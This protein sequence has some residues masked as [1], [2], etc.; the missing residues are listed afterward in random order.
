[1][2]SVKTPTD[3]YDAPA[4]GTIVNENSSVASASEWTESESTRDRQT[5]VVSC[6]ADARTGQKATVD[7][8]TGSSTD[9]T[10]PS[11][12]PFEG[13]DLIKPLHE[14]AN[15]DGHSPFA[16][17]ASAHYSALTSLSG[18]SK[19]L[20]PS[21]VIGTET[22]RQIADPTSNR[23]S[24]ASIRNDARQSELMILNTENRRSS[25]AMESLTINKL[26][27]SSLG[28]VGRDREISVLESC[29]GRLL[30]SSQGTENRTAD[31]PTP[32]IHNELVFIQGYS[33][34]G[35][36]TM[37]RSLQTIVEKSPDGVY[38]EGKYEFTSTDEP[39]SGVAQ[40]FGKLCDRFG[41]CSKE[42]VS[43]I[44]DIIMDTMKEEAIMLMGLIP[45][46]SI[47]WNTDETTPRNALSEAH[48]FGNDHE[49]WKYAFRTL[50]QIL[51]S[52]LSPIV[53]V[54]DDIQWADIS[55]L[56]IMDCLISDVKNPHPVMMIGCYRSNE[57]DEN[58]IL[59]NR[60][61]TLE[62]KKEYL[63]FH[64]TD[65][66]LDSFDVYDVNK[67]IM[68]MMSIDDESTT[69]P[70]AEVC[71]KRTLGNPF[72]LIEFMRVLH[73]EKLLEFNLGLMK[74]VWKTKKIEDA[75]MSTANV[76]DLLQNRMRKLSKDQQLLLQY[77]ACLGS[78][79]FAPNI[80]FVWKEHALALSL[81]SNKDVV[82]MLEVVKDANFIELCGE[83]EYRWVHDKV[84]EAAFSLS[85]LVTPS[86][87]CALGVCLFQG[88][89]DSQLE[90]QLFDVVDLINKG[91]AIES[92]ELAELNLR[93]AK[94]ARRIAAFQS[95]A[96]YANSGIKLLSSDDMWRTNRELLLELY[97]LS[98][99]M[100]L[101]I[102]RIN[103][104]DVRIQTV[105]ARKIFT[106]EETMR[107]QIIKVANLYSVELRFDEAV[108]YGV[109]VLKEIG[110]NF[111]WPKKLV[112]L[113]AL[114]LMT[115]TIKK[116]M[117]LPASHFNNIP[118]M[119]DPKH[120]SIVQMLSKLHHATYNV[121]DL[122][123]NFVVICRSISLTLKHGP[124][125]LSAPK[126][127]ALA[128]CWM[129]IKND[130]ATCSHILKLIFSIQRRF[131]IRNAAETYAT[132]LGFVQCYMKPLHESL[133]PALGG[134]VQGLKDGEIE[135][136]MS[137][138]CLR[139]LYLPYL[140]G[141]P[142]SS[143]VEEFP[144]LAAQLEE[145]KRAKELWA[146]RALWKMMLNLQV[147]PDEAS[148][149]LDG[150]DLELS[151]DDR[152]SWHVGFTNF[153]IGEMLLF[154]FTD[155]EARVERLLG[156][157][158]GNTFPE[159]IPA[160]LL[161]TIDTFHRGIAWYAMARRT[162]RKRYKSEAK[163]IRKAVSSWVSAG[164]P[165]V[166][167]YD[168]L[169]SAEQAVLDKKY[170]KADDFYRRAIVS[171]ARGGFLH[172]AALFNERFAEYRIDIHGDIDD[173]KYYTQEAIRYYTDW[174]AVGKAKELEQNM[175][176]CNDSD[177]SND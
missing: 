130:H 52:H 121:G 37:A 96:N 70:L 132:S 145:A 174:G 91:N 12:P 49:R 89:E 5:L 109:R 21:I 134:Y 143:I 66:L 7:Y 139:F 46:L 169:L 30:S 35:K 83:D 127:A 113:Q 154:L 100:E 94:K 99:E 87:Q 18:F 79:I 73:T 22:T 26:K 133:Q 65:I 108:T 71:H 90:K 110:Y 156:E 123:L 155:H 140:M 11:Q 170:D 32:P 40:A 151:E 55:S 166:V 102:G 167:H 38:V 131:G 33:G 13:L 56:D 43:E 23:I 115:K 163:K 25:I 175:I 171:A 122:P 147:P 107:L 41:D 84:Q 120:L 103:V 141:K 88:L 172:H 97:T 63:S 150:E 105:L 118:L 57:V 6:E 14:S 101:A 53:I 124:N 1:M 75:T 142:L 119:Q 4:T 16:D 144:K 128:A 72:F 39:Y 77:A 92:L 129:F 48:N 164:N 42:T 28:V 10:V 116:L 20:V 112:P 176:R 95:G 34:I 111:V 93:A 82:A 98:A 148:K 8:S 177:F 68:S 153:A 137:C 138:L 51:G 29:F 69:L 125:D 173:Y 80:T 159:K 135:N 45:E 165:N 9:C 58:S 104:V 17:D 27:F 47:F 3:E 86:F 31:D 62:E 152:K 136:A 158:K 117:A 161:G 60:I 15:N 146:F 36:S 106:T 54:L 24:G 85:D 114:M 126:L 76:V 67:L 64:I 78:S 44:S 19:D 162:G 81:S 157:E 160:F 59:Y 168:L 61:K 2:P 74:W 149:K 50:T